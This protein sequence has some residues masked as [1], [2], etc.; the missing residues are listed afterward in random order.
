M[1]IGRQTKAGTTLPYLMLEY[2]TNGA[3][4]SDTGL[5]ATPNGD[6]RSYHATDN[7]MS[8]TYRGRTPDQ[9]IDS[10]AIAG[11]HYHTSLQTELVFHM[12]GAVTEHGKIGLLSI[13]PGRGTARRQYVEAV[14]R[15]DHTLQGEGSH[16]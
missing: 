16:R 1:I 11:I 14:E 4:D 8:D 6:P 7:L 9:M 12:L 3:Y 15:L 5:F 2:L 13:A 10:A